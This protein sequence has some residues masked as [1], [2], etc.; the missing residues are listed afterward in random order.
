MKKRTEIGRVGSN[1]RS[2]LV[3]PMK[4]EGD[5]QWQSTMVE[6]TRI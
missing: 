2:S 4:L 3:E 5:E 1:D 6:T